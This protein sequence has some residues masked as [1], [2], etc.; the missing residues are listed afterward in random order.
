[1]ELDPE[2]LK[3][4]LATFTEE[5]NEQCESIANHLLQLEKAP[6][7]FTHIESIFRSAHNIKGAARGIGVTNVGE[8]AH[9]LETLFSNIENQTIILTPSIIDLSLE[10]IDNMRA[11][12]EAF[13][14]KN[15][16]PLS[17]LHF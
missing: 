2:L 11:S 5:L 16:C 13:S 12:L 9:H 14:E 10:A 3:K 6:S 4:L 1:M 17:W 15:R 8:I 7:D